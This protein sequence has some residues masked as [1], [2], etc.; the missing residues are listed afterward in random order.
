MFVQD[1][2]EA[3]NYFYLVWNKQKN[4][5]PLEPIE[6]IIADVIVEHPEYHHYLEVKETSKENDFCPEGNQTNPFLH[7]G[8]HIA[9]KEQASSD[10]P[11]GIKKII[12]KVMSNSDSMHDAEHKMME[13]L[14]QILWEAQR[15]NSVPDDNKYLESLNKIC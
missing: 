11:L 13:C 1:R 6:V 2:N 3:R 14:G 7:M 12:K 5:L 4:K 9:L 15:S 8:M 10:R